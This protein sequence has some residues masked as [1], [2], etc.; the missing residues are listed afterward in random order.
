MGVRTAMSQPAHRWTAV[1]AVVGLLAARPAAA[2]ECATPTTL[3]HLTTLMD[4]AERQFAD[5]NS[6]AFDSLMEMQLAPTLQCLGEALTPSLALRYHWLVAYHNL[7]QQEKDTVEALAS[8]R[9][10]TGDGPSPADTYPDGH[11]IR[12]HYQAASPEVLTRRLSKPRSGRLT[13]DG[14]ETR[15]RPIDR[16]TI[17]Q[18]LREDGG[19]E[20]T[21]Y[22]FSR[23]VPARYD[24]ISDADLVGADSPARRGF[25][26][27]VPLLVTTGT[28]AVASGVLYGV[29]GTSEAAFKDTGTERTLDELEGLRSR[30]NAAGVTAG[31][32]AIGAGVGLGAF[33]VVG[34]F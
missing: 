10:L 20:A 14:A 11:P 30:T 1:L 4:E 8:A 17:Q 7:D 6:V 3:S 2:G 21:A 31:A 27:N 28:L 13:F 12:Q 22:L 32:L 26:V 16:A 24:G 15:A 25:V 5:M 19:V 29:A 9:G 18:V 33:V 23:N 34:A